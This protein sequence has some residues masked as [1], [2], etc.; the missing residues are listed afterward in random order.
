M[1]DALEDHEGTVSTGGRTIT[2][3]RF[4]DDIDGLAG[5]EELANLVERL[6]KA[7]TA[8][9]MEISAEKAKLTTNNTNGINTEIKVNGQKLETV[10]G[11]RYL[12]SVITYEGSKPEIL[13][14]IAQTT[15]AL[16]KLTPVWNDRSISLSSKIQL[17]RSLVICIFRYACESWTL[18]AEFQRRIQAME[19]RCATARYY[20][21]HTKTMLPT[22]KSVPRSSRQ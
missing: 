18:T 7:S 16:T 8:Y 21:S 22:R 17:M 4:A 20:T 19:M 1:K 5:E 10:T 3:L 9:G 2:N 12:G 14:R 11:F 13:S 15:A 6:D